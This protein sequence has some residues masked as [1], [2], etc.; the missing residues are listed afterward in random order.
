MKK[1]IFDFYNKLNV[2]SNKDI[3]VVKPEGF[4][5]N[6]DT[7]EVR[8]YIV[9]L[10]IQHLLEKGEIAEN[11]FEII[12]ENHEREFNEFMDFIRS[13]KDKDHFEFHID[14][15]DE[16]QNIAIYRTGKKMKYSAD[17]RFKEDGLWFLENEEEGVLT[18][19]VLNWIKSI[20][21]AEYMRQG[22]CNVDCD[23]HF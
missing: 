23:I 2:K 17:Y 4:N 7:V 3:I 5:R 18:S 14:Y 16:V 1:V 20:F 11:D 22:W 8:Q 19:E 13:F 21:D 10:A 6:N 9:D 12:T 15:N